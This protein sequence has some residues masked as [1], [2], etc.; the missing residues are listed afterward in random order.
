[1][2]EHDP[3]RTLVFHPTAR[4]VVH[5]GAFR[6]DLAD[7]LLSRGGEEVHLA[8]RALVILQH[9][10][11]RAGRVVPKQALMDAAWK[12]AYVSETSLTEAIG[13]LRQALGDDP[14]KPAYIQTVHRRGYRFIAPIST[15]LPAA[16]PPLHDRARQIPGDAAEVDPRAPQPPAEP[17]AA[18]RRWRAGFAILLGLA[19][20]ATA[21]VGWLALTSGDA[22]PV[23]RVS[24][25]LPPEQAPAPGLNAH[26]VATI[27]P[28][29]QQIVY[30]A[31]NPGA[32]RLFVRRM[33]RFEATP[34]A[35]TDGAHGPFFSPDGQW[36]GFFADGRVKKVRL[37]GGE[38]QVLC[39]TPTGVGG[40]WLSDDEIVFAPDW[41]GPLMRV[42]ASGGRPEVAATPQPGFSYRWPDRLDDHTLIATRWRSTAADA[43]VVAVSLTSGAEQVIAEHAM[44][45][46]YL[47]TSAVMFVRDE[48]VHAVRIDRST[49]APRGG[50]VRMLP[51]VL[52]GMTGAAQLAVAPN[53]TLLYLPDIADRSRRILARANR[54]EHS[55]DLPIAPRP[56][57]NLAVCGDRIAVTIYEHG[58]SDLWT[59]HLGRA[60]LTRIT[61]EGSVVEPV[62]SAD[63]RTLAFA[64][65][66][67]GV[68]NMYTVELGSGEAPK[69]L[70]AS[71]LP[72]TPGSWSGNGRWLAYIEHTSRTLSDIW[73]MD[74]GTGRAKL[75]EATPAQELLPRL[76]PDGRWLAYESDASGRFQIEVASVTRGSRVQVST[77]GGI[78]PAWSADGTELFFLNDQTIYTA[79]IGERD[80]ELIAG[81]PLPL[82]SHPDLLLFRPAGNQFVW[83]RRTAEHLPLTKI[84]L[85]L[86]WFSE[87]DRLLP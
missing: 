36:V 69:R 14:Q 82:F 61:E 1:M 13:L 58:Q 83:L 20:L 68:A 57:R 67:T 60:A 37:D 4:S 55:Q 15:D 75:F 43:A 63:C 7:G 59:G 52:T 74:R 26:P 46:R 49:H 21:G 5:F 17:R 10:I 51:A 29:G 73:L 56:F 6:F 2:Q 9:L 81:N 25:T 85:V 3:A 78:W 23:V 32:T 22:Q 8:P 77:S 30:V 16:Q 70:A 45:G 42:S 28:D 80:G 71:R 66:R 50:P 72:Q 65:N 12:D 33:D 34:L 44:F 48:D 86:G 39:A 35:G 64:W 62:W 41:I 11:E 79:A 38:P 19:V 76:S 84:N 31:G 40:T 27:S 87:L 53:G 24:L 47:S 54:Q 18:P